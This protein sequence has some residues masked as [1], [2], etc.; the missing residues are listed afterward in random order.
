VRVGLLFPGEMGAEVG[1]AVRT[2]VLWASEGRS[3]ATAER[4]ARAGLV[5][6]GSL[7]EL[8][9]SSEI[10]LSVCPPAIAEDVAVQVF[11]L[12]FSGL[13]VEAN[14]ISPARMA[15]IAELGAR[16]VDGSIIGRDGIRLYLA[17][18]PDDVQ[19]VAALF[20]G[21]AVEA[22]PLG[23]AVGAASALKMAFGGW[24]KIGVALA[25]QAH[26]IARAYGVEDALE[27][28][29]VA[30]ERVSRA[31]P[32]A[33]RWAPEMAEVAATC[34]ELGLPESIGKG[35]AE[36]YARWDEHRDTDVP[37]DQLLDDLVASSA[38]SQRHRPVI[39]DGR[40]GKARTS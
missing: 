30:G 23:A 20:E 33:W 3:R 10:I 13:Y 11:D 18:S 29:G 22:I 24:N 25:A 37:L 31:A 27:A 36:L 1:A 12:G 14:A 2:E 34:S 19:E 17:G 4:A 39:A 6:V 26:A 40:A 35:A 21:T 28:E 16:I 8:V 7:A 15:R 38:P 32:K 5:D 9:A